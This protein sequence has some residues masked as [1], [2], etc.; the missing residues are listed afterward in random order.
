MKLRRF[1][2]EEIFAAITVLVT[3]ALLDRE[4]DGPGLLTLRDSRGPGTPVIVV[5]VCRDKG[6]EEWVMSRPGRAVNDGDVKK[7]WVH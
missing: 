1:T 7:G 6:L 2:Q 3:E 5:D 4:R